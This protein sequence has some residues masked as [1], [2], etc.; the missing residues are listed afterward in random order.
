MNVR[1]PGVL[2]T[3]IFYQKCFYDGLK[4]LFSGDDTEIQIII[5]KM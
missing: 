4:A 1:Q 5:P 3:F 2:L